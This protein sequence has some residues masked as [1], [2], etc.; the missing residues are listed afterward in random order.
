MNSNSL[1]KVIFA[2][3]I[4]YEVTLLITEQQIPSF[5]V[6]I[7]WGAFFFIRERKIGLK[8]MKADFDPLHKIKQIINNS[9]T[10]VDINEIMVNEFPR[11][12]FQVMC[13]K[14][15]EINGGD[16]SL[17]GMSFS[18][19]DILTVSEIYSEGNRDLYVVFREMPKIQI[20]LDFTN[21]IYVGELNEATVK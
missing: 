16:K 4:S 11:F 10:P 2:M 6:S 21:F 12:P 7:I 20:P 9:F 18:T 8:K 15:I 17:G 19:G 3:I 13:H 5:M 14:P 1:A